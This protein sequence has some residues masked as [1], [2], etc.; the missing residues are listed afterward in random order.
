MGNGISKQ[1]VDPKL[2]LSVLQGMGRGP[3]QSQP[4]TDWMPFI[5]NIAQMAYLGT[6]PALSAREQQQLM[7][8]MYGAE[9]G[10]GWM[11]GMNVGDL[12]MSQQGQD[13]ATKQQYIPPTT[14]AAA[15]NRQNPQGTQKAQPT[16]YGERAKAWKVFDDIAQS[17]T[18][19]TPDKML[20]EIDALGAKKRD[21]YR[22]LGE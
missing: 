17:P 14:N 13:P 5:R 20:S 22:A 16:E 21:V 9:P 1:A 4:A 8:G 7:A 15:F 3:Q 10:Q 18:S 12:Y 2:A 11:G 19:L 6:L